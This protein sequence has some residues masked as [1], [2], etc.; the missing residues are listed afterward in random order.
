VTWQ[1]LLAIIA[2][3]AAVL[4]G[5]PLGGAMSE[6]RLRIPGALGGLVGAALTAAGVFALSTKIVLDPLSYALGSFL[7]STTGAIIGTL[8][9]N[10]LF[11]LRDRRPS[12]V[13]IDV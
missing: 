2:F 3:I 13:S 10:F 7:V 8:V 11:S 5:I 1:L 12:G 4:V 6:R 9:V